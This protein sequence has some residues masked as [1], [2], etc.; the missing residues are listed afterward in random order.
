[1]IPVILRDMR[2][3]L[4]VLLLFAWLFYLMEPGFHVHEVVDA[5]DDPGLAPA[6]IAFTLAN[7]AGLGMVLLLGG[8]A[9][10]DRRRGYYRILFSHP[11]SPLAYYGLRWG[12]AYVLAFGVAAAFWVVGQMVAWGE[13]RAGPSALAQPAL[14]ALVYGGLLAFLATVLPRGEG[15]VTVA[16]FVA[17]ELWKSLLTEL[18][19]QPFNAAVRGAVWLLLP[20][21]LPLSA[22]QESMA[23]GAVSWGAVGFAAGYGL[24][25]LLLA[26][27]VL[28]VREWP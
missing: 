4:A 28:R 24:F 1:M 8:T 27:L 17:A 9:S 13:M 3:R 12:V 20:P 25:F 5:P 15:W 11:V 22:V 16:L 10:A 26:T 6:G 18:G 14:F 19:L 23:R 7:L 21:H 2:W